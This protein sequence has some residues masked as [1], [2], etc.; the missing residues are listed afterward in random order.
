MPLTTIIKGYM[1]KRAEKIEFN[2]L[3][4]KGFPTVIMCTAICFFLIFTE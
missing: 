3:G 1:W 4:I 2:I